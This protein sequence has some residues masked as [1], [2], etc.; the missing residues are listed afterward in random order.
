MNSGYG[1]GVRQDN[2]SEG[3]FRCR[4]LRRFVIRAYDS[5]EK[6]YREKKPHP[7]KSAKGRA[8]SFGE[9]CAKPSRK[10]LDEFSFRLYV[11]QRISPACEV[12]DA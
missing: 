9:E 2:W 3:R 4:W 1:M 11:A 12:T 5:M 10:K 7:L 6:S 8:P